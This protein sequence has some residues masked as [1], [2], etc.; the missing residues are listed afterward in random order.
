MKAMKCITIPNENMSALVE[1]SLILLVPVLSQSRRDLTA[2]EFRGSILLSACQRTRVLQLSQ[3]RPFLILQHVPLRSHLPKL[4]ESGLSRSKSN[5]FPALSH[6]YHQ[7]H[8]IDL[9]E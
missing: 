8:L 2:N 6:D 4:W 1:R 9:T 5:N 3:F 7:R